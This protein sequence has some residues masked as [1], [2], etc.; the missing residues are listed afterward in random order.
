MEDNNEN[1]ISKFYLSLNERMELGDKIFVMDKQGNKYT[2][3][4]DGEDEN[5]ISIKID[6][7][8]GVYYYMFARSKI[9]FIKTYYEK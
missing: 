2:G 6:D 5:H 7:G 8:N 3:E 9:E 1:I 4:Y